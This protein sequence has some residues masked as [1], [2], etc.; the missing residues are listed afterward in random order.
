MERIH[1]LAAHMPEDM[2]AILIDG[3]YNRLYYTGMHSS[4]GT[5]V[6]TRDE[7]YFIIDFRY[8]EVAKNTVKGCEVI[9]QKKLYEQLSEIFKKHGIRRLGI[10]ETKT[11]DE[12]LTLKEKLPEVEVMLDRRIGN[13]IAKQRRI[14]EPC[15]LESIRRAQDYTDRAFS[16]I[17]EFIQPGRTEKEI[18]L[19]LEF[20]ARR[21]GAEGASFEYIVVAG[22]NGSLPHGHPSDRPVEKGDFITMDFGCLADGY[23]SDMTRTVAVGEPGEEKRKVYETVLQANLSAMAAIRAGVPCKEID[24]VARDII[25]N[26]GYGDCFGH[27]LGHSVGLEIHES[28]RFSYTSDEICEAGLIMTDEPGI[29]LEGRFG[30]RIEDM[31]YVTEDGCI[32]LTKSDKNLIVL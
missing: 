4:A 32:N 19:E 24:K 7:A 10:E 17:C 2:D 1:Q 29:Y 15:E 30:V 14:K 21:L 23:C 27:G 22:P 13:L 9:L 16:H 25:A 8:I 28:P 20:Y 3:A 5:L 11:M 6:V 18:A 12:Y 26:A 31:V